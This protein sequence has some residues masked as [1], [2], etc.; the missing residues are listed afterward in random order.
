[1][2]FTYL[3]VVSCFQR[4]F[5]LEFHKPILTLKEQRHLRDFG[6]VQRIK[7]N[8][9]SVSAFIVVDSVH[10]AEY[11]LETLRNVRKYVTVF[12]FIKDVKIYNENNDTISA[13]IKVKFNLYANVV[14]DFKKKYKLQVYS[15]E[16]R[17][18]I[19]KQFKAQ[20]LIDDSRVYLFVDISNIS[21]IPTYVTNILTK[22]ALMKTTNWLM[23]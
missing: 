6:R 16:T 5:S 23:K 8:E 7:K 18:N 10:N 13:K 15:D 1:M 3:L 12:N 11:I 14:L 4:I 17:D 22:H 2:I 9:E 20:W 19:F 21:V